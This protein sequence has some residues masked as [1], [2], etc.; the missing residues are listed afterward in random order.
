[1]EAEEALRAIRQGNVDTVVVA[2]GQG[3]QVYTLRG[4]EHAYRVLIESMHEGALTL[5]AD[6]MILF[7]NQRFARMVRCP[8][9]QVTGSSFHRFLSPADHANLR[10]LMKR[11]ARS[12]SQMLLQLKTGS[13]SW[14]PVQISVRELPKDGSDRVTIGMVVTDMTEARRTEERLRAL[15]HRVVEVQESERARVA[16]DLHDHIT[17]LL[18]GALFRSQALATRLGA[19]DPD[20][21]REAVKLREMIGQTAHAVERI[22]REL[23]SSV[24]AELGLVAALRAISTEFT[25]RTGVAIRLSCVELGA[26]RPDIELAFYRIFQAALRNVEKHARAHRI[27]V[28]LTVQGG[29]ARLS[30]Q[31]DGIGFNPARRA[32]GRRGIGGLGLLGMRERATYLGGT[33]T[34]ESATGG[35]TEIDVRI[36][37]PPAAVA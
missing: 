23:R 25:V 32:G 24:L 27:A 14:L 34:V 20:L 17:Q 28:R 36:P 18:C 9:E 16:L 33:L 8:L 3:R 37:L 11:A 31:D 12:G 15:T 21:Q 22:S 4:A 29:V 10:P 13:D 5:T 19:Q 7:A 26:R 2:G 6:K 1:M 35:G 30:I